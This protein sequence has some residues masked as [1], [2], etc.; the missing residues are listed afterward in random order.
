VLGTPAT[1]ER[2]GETGFSSS[3]DPL[4]SGRGEVDLFRSV[5]A[6]GAHEVIVHCPQHATSV[7][8]LDDE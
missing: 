2:V 7:G 3:A 4:G 8:D 1:S 6:E 5:P